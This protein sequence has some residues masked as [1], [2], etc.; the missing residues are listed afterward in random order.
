MASDTRITAS[1]T[2]TRAINHSASLTVDIP[3]F[4]R[5]A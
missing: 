3:S 5:K 2:K 1:V 4:V